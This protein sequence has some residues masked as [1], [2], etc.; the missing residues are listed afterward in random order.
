[1]LL[2]AVLVATASAGCGTVKLASRLDEAPLFPRIE[3]RVGT[4]IATAA[5]Q[6]MIVNPLLRIEVGKDSERDF[7]RTFASMF[8]TTTPLPDWPPWRDLDDQARGRMDAVIELVRM[9][10]ALTLGNDRSSSNL[11]LRGL[12]GGEP[13]VVRIAYEVCLYQP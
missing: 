10:A 6:A 3:A 1:M 4:V 12:Q 5:R 11:L 7:E 2:A 13:D 8:T 9:D